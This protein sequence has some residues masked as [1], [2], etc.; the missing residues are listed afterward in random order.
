MPW[1]VWVVVGVSLLVLA[2]I[3]WPFSRRVREETG[4]DPETEAFLL[5]GE[6][7]PDGEERPLGPPRPRDFDPGELRALQEIGQSEDPSP[8][9]R[10]SRRR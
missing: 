4:M 5:L 9:R 8:R 3:V 7:P 2:L 10:R 6:T 1:V